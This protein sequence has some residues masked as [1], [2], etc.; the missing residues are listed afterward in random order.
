MQKQGPQFKLQVVGNLFRGFT[1]T[2]DQHNI[3]LKI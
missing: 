2:I 1:L 3:F